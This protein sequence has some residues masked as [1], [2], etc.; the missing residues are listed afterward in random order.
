MKC[1]NPLA[2]IIRLYD[3]DTYTDLPCTHIDYNV[4]RCPHCQKGLFRIYDGWQSSYRK[5]NLQ[6]TNTNCKGQLASIKYF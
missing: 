5:T 1:R 3:G 4:W 2:V 6:C